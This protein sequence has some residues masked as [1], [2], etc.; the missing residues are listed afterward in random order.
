MQGDD[1]TH[2]Y[3]CIPIYLYTVH[4]RCTGTVGSEYLC[5]YN[6]NAGISI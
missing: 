3:I 1:Y 4:S 6:E 5:R 2:S